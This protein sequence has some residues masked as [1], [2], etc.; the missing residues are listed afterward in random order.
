MTVTN[1]VINLFLHF[2]MPHANITITTK[3]KDI[4]ISI[5]MLLER[6]IFNGNCKTMFCD[7]MGSLFIYLF[8]KNDTAVIWTQAQIH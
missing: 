1:A 2:E 8:I 7:S 3:I 4:L 6:Y 5:N